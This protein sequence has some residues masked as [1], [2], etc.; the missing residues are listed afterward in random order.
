MNT[1]LGADRE[2]MMDVPP[3]SFEM[4]LRCLI[5]LSQKAGRSIGYGRARGPL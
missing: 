4:K 3:F 2:I 1:V 5:G